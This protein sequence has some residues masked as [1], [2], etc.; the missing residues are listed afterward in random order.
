MKLKKRLLASFL[1]FVLALPS[2]PATTARADNNA[3]GTSFETAGELTL[4]TEQQ[5]TLS[6]VFIDNNMSYLAYYR[7]TPEETGTYKFTVSNNNM[8]GF[9]TAIY[10][11]DIYRNILSESAAEDIFVYLNQGMTYYFEISNSMPIPF[12]ALLQKNTEFCAY[13][14]GLSNIN[15][16]YNETHQLQVNVDGAAG[17]VSYQWYKEYYNGENNEIVETMLQGETQSSYTVRATKENIGHYYCDVTAMDNE[18]NQEN[19]RVDF[20][21]STSTN[22]SV[23]PLDTEVEL[24]FGESVTLEVTASSDAG[25][26]SLSY[27]WH[28]QGNMGDNIIEGVN[29]SAYTVSGVKGAGAC[30]VCE[31]TDGIETEYA[32]FYVYLRSNLNAEADGPQNISLQYLEQK[33][34]HILT[35]GAADD[36]NYQWYKNNTEIEG[37]TTDTYL[38]KGDKDS[39]G[40]Y[41]C[42]VSDGISSDFV[43]YNVSVETGLA[44][45]AS[46][47]EPEE[48][49]GRIDY[50]VNVPYQQK[51]LL[52]VEAS[53]GIGTLSY[54]WYRMP[55]YWELD[56]DE[57]EI[58]DG[59][60][61]DTYELTGISGVNGHYCCKISD[62]VISKFVYFDVRIDTGLTVNTEIESIELTYGDSCVLK[63]NASGGTGPLTY[64][65]YNEDTYEEIEGATSDSYSLPEPVKESSFHCEVTDGVVTKYVYFNVYVDTQLHITSNSGTVKDGICTVSVQ[66]GKPVVFNVS[67]SSLAG[68]ITYEW[69][70]DGAY[71]GE[72]ID[73]ATETS[74]QIPSDAP[75]A[76]FYVCRVSD[77][78]NYEDYYFYLNTGLSVNST[79]GET[80]GVYD[81]KWIDR[82]VPL[83]EAG[84]TTLSVNASGGIGTLS[85]QWYGSDDTYN[86]KEN[87]IS[88]ASSGTLELEKPKYKYYN[89]EISDDFCKKSISFYM[90]KDYRLKVESAV[91]F[92]GQ[93]H[94]SYNNTYYMVKAERNVPVE[95]KVNASCGNET[96]SCQWFKDGGF[97]SDDTAMEGQTS[98]SLTVTPD[99]NVTYYCKIRAGEIEKK[100]YFDVAVD[101][102]FTSNPEAGTL[103]V[104]GTG[105][106][107][108]R[109]LYY[110]GCMENSERTLKVV[111]ED[112]VTS[113]AEGAFFISRYD[114]SPALDITI[115]DSVT[116][117]SE[118]S[119]LIF[120]DCTIRCH[121]GSKAHEYATKNKINVELLPDSVSLSDCTVTVTPESTPYTGTAINPQ[122]TVMHGQKRLTQG[123]DYTVSV[124]DNLNAGTATVTIK[125]K[126]SYTGEAKKTF[127]ITAQDISKASITLAQTDC[128]YNGKEQK[129]SVT[130]V[131]LGNITLV[132]DKDYTIAYA[133]NTDIGTAKALITGKGNYTG[134]VEKTFTITASKNSV[135]T[136]ASCEYKITGGSEVSFAGLKNSKTSKLTIPKTVKIGGKTFKVTSIANQ[137]FKKTNVT[138]LTISDS[139]KTIG[140]SAFEGCSKLKKVTIGK[141]VT[142][143]GSNAFKNCKKLGSITIKSTKLKSVGKNALK[144]IKSNAKIKVP[145]K[146]LKSYQKLFKGK[147]QGKKV[148]LIK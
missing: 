58:I 123:T 96:V 102:D 11:N 18:N 136:S 23:T 134:T 75:A 130:A 93:K 5:G 25:A 33:S 97:Y 86:L 101:V 108:N 99:K 71:N 143:I 8:D 111:I 32:Q 29:G 68:P 47:G 138:T 19:R 12:T 46:V 72:L 94:E 120:N 140:N 1:A 50:H 62:D 53:G 110:S 3:A 113:L 56:E 74:Y 128:T 129:P 17:T 26:D 70:R 69:Y 133:Q 127:T 31:V 35:T 76:N 87:T 82:K 48:G 14:A 40:R 81:D 2:L 100:V 116:D 13:P 137:A 119:I 73:G 85:Y 44:A 66:E 142:K 15:I 126:G 147:G 49:D 41:K 118:Q 67:A 59:A 121:E 64:Q 90:D 91:P 28:K 61:S 55:V 98:N 36:V 38:L 117:I 30:Y 78:V 51:S 92:K 60:V 57:L 21:V 80:G 42:T 109:I 95:L 124:T 125:G 52:K 77:T 7:Y 39:T 45:D 79:S 103:T 63:V 54:Q 139:V 83:P 132:P 146:K 10:D 22:L 148:K 106:V 144:S 104:T 115:P 24:N 135:Y 43:Y 107:P 34:L 84:K 65:W 105:E 112:G 141:D 6:P 20:Y 89:C 37:A 9:S 145:S 27:Q 114:R 88:G 4:D 122:V 16:P 131:K